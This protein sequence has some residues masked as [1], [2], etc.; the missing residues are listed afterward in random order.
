MHIEYSANF[1]KVLISTAAAPRSGS[2][3]AK[4]TFKGSPSQ[5][6]LHGKQPFC[7]FEPP[8][9]GLGATYDINLRLEI[10]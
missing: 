6:F 10:A 3:D 8:I 5:S 1:V 2:L 9:G 7:I 4:S